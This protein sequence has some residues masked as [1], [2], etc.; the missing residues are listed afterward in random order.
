MSAGYRRDY[1]RLASGIDQPDGGLC[2]LIT[3]FALIECA[4]R[5]IARDRKKRNV[6]ARD[7]IDVTRDWQVHIASSNLVLIDEI[8]Q[9]FECSSQN[10]N[11]VTRLPQFLPL[12][13]S[14]STRTNERVFHFCLLRP[15]Q[16]FLHNSIKFL[17]ICAFREARAKR[18]AISSST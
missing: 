17:R 15:A 6:T 1:Q 3:S 4:L 16:N 14:Q 8:T 18:N 7:G 11:N 2:L 9:L 10:T 5:E 12:F 13:Y